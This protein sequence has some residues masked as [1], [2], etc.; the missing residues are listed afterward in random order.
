MPSSIAAQVAAQPSRIQPRNG[1]TG[2]DPWG[3]PLTAHH[4]AEVDRAQGTIPNAIVIDTDGVVVLG[5]SG[6]H[7][8][9]DRAHDGDEEPADQPADDLRAC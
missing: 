5:S 4:Q 1:N 2:V 7:C 3:L 8:S 9:T 6:P